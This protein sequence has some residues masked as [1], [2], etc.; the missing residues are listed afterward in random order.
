MQPN[1]H[2]ARIVFLIFLCLV[3]IVGCNKQEDKSYA[4][5]ILN[6]SDKFTSDVGTSAI[7][8]ACREIFPE[9]GAVVESSEP[10]PEKP[11]W[12][13]LSPDELTQVNVTDVLVGAYVPGME[14][15][16]ALLA[17]GKG[18]RL[19]WRI[20]VPVENNL[21]LFIRAVEFELFIGGSSKESLQCQVS[22]TL[23]KWDDCKSLTAYN[24]IVEMN[25]PPQGLREVEIPVGDWKDC[26]IVRIITAATD[27][28]ELE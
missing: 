24:E 13:I 10:E 20:S 26:C 25:I 15:R 12:R 7:K 23:G 11:I 21:D 8:A 3:S 4:D 9:P 1:P 22:A 17:A 27:N 28:P 6:N 16:V 19:D 5:C 2:I 18:T 14:R